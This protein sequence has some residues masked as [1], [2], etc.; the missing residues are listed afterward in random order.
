M[1]SVDIIRE[2]GMESGARNLFVKVA[3]ATLLLFLDVERQ[4]QNALH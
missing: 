2:L 4:Y 1:D 3:T